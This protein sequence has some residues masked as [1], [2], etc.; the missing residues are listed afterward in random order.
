M[1]RLVYPHRSEINFTAECN[2]GPGTQKEGADCS[3]APQNDRSWNYVSR[4][5]FFSALPIDGAKTVIIPLEVS[6]LKPS[7]NLPEGLARVALVTP[8]YLILLRAEFSCFHS[9]DSLQGSRSRLQD[10]CP[11]HSLCSTVPRLTA[12]GR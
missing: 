8:S 2:L 12:E 10:Q 7:S 1:L 9:G 11:G 4:I 5:L 6:L 3:S